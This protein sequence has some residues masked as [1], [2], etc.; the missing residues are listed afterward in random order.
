MWPDANDELSAV[1][2][3]KLPT[4]DPSLLFQRIAE[5]RHT[6]AFVADAVCDRVTSVGALFQHG[7][8]G[9]AGSHGA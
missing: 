1:V 2:P 5:Q 3:K 6:N 8:D 9:D 4:W 7:P